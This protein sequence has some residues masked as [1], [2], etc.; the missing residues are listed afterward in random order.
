MSTEANKRL[1]EQVYTGLS[2]G[3]TDLLF[4]SLHEGARWTIIGSTPL[5]GVF[6]GK[7]AIMDGLITPLRARLA[8]RIA[9]SFERLIAEGEH[10]V[11]QMRG[12]ATAS[13]GDPYNQTYCI[14]AR[15]VDGRIVEMTDYVD[16]E[17]ATQALFGGT[18]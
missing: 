8:S 18:R 10:V 1:L 3:N 17:L 12:N 11:M 9:F 15:I 13:T 5:S 16:T 7:Q 14:V 6:H 2:R 4:D